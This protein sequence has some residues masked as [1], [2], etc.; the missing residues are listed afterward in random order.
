MTVKIIEFE[1]G[2]RMSENE[3][4]DIAEKV[5]K[6][7]LSELPEE[8][9]TYDGASYMLKKVKGKLKTLKIYYKTSQS[10]AEQ[11]LER[12]AGQEVIG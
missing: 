12:V 7:M 10:N 2:F 11:E 5:A 6:M 1:N 3:I 9:Q 4:M 8:I